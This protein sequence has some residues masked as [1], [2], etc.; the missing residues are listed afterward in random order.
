MMCAGHKKDL[1]FL[2]SLPGASER[3]EIFDADLDNPKS[4]VAAIEGCTGVFHVATP[5]DFG[6]KE[7]TEIVIKR[8]IDGAIGILQASL[9]SKTVKKVVYTSSSVTVLFNGKDLDEMDESFWTDIDYV[10][11]LNSHVS[12]YLI[13]K[14]LTEKAILNFSEK[15][16]LDVATLILCYISGPF[17]CPEIPRSV[18]S[19]F[20]MI[21][22]NKSESNTLTRFDT[23]HVDDVARAQIFLFENPKAKGRY[24]CSA[25]IIEVESTAKLLSTK[26]PGLKFPCKGSQIIMKADWPSLSSKKL[27]ESGFQY[28]YGVEEMF[29]DAVKSSKEKGYL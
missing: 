18:V 11:S 15:H 16:G 29:D 7:S 12:C 27:I 24:N 2:K 21:V 19:V 1:S 9:D 28:K 22:G 17:I 20:E 8:S 6:N 3:L 5:L 4:F 23:A 26:Y 14:T 10:N 25:N 13:S